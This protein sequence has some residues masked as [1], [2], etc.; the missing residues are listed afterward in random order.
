[1]LKLASA[2]LLFALAAVNISHSQCTLVL[3]GGYTCTPPTSTAQAQTILNLLSASDVSGLSVK[4]AAGTYDFPSQ[5]QL[6]SSWMN[7]EGSGKASTVFRFTGTGTHGIISY[8]GSQVIKNIWITRNNSDHTASGAAIALLGEANRIE[9]CMLTRFYHGVYL[10]GNPWSNSIVNCDIRGNTNGIVTEGGDANN[11]TIERCRIICNAMYGVW[12]RSPS[13]APYPRSMAVRII[14]NTL[15]QNGRSAVN[16]E[17]ATGVVIANN[18]F[19]SNEWSVAN[20]DA[21]S[22]KDANIRLAETNGG[23]IR[24]ISILDN[25]FGNFYYGDGH[26]SSF[27]AVQPDA[28]KKSSP[29]D[30]QNLA[31]WR[32]TAGTVGNLRQAGNY[33]VDYTVNTDPAL[34]NKGFS[35]SFRYSPET[36]L[37]GTN[38]YSVF[39]KVRIYSGAGV[40]TMTAPQGSLYLR[41]DGST[42]AFYVRQAGYWVGK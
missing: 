28:T 33:Y 7:I 23:Q 12:L 34:P 13:G 24:N 20:D 5:M 11:F 18:Y 25:Y 41:N 17:S 32:I 4:F 26:N 15:E 39:G 22:T 14:N 8:E 2:A 9:N 1:M 27:E 29:T 37:S 35:D 42:P 36:I 21:G 31:S 38:A 40:P 3:G 30:K 6:G 16:I 10:N 19:E